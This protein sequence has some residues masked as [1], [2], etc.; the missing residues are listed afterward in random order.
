MPNSAKE[1]ERTF[2]IPPTSYIIVDS[3][4]EQP[5]SDNEIQELVDLRTDQSG[6]WYNFVQK[7][8]IKTF[9]P[10]VHAVYSKACNIV[11]KNQDAVK[12]IECWANELSV[13]DDFGMHSDV[14]E[15]LFKRTR[16]I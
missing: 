16:Q 11:L 5:F 10:K 3:F 14:D 15:A 13:G 4:L 1:L 12:G 7:D 2:A 6:N 9:N 8:E